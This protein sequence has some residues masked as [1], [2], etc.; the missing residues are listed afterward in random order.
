MSKFWKALGITTVLAALVPVSIKEDKETGKKTYQSLLM[1]LNVKTDE[2]AKEKQIGLNI[3][4][5]VISSA[6]INAVTAK[7]EAELFTDDP[8]E[9]V[10]TEAQAIADEAQAAAGTAQAIIDDVQGIAD[11]AQ[12]AVGGAQAVIDAVKNV[13]DETPASTPVIADFEDEV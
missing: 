8:A 6:I 5:G 4:D 10:V 9:A 12:A 2:A 11:E 1:S 3:G 13:A 7:R